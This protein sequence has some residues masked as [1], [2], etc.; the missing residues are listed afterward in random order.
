MIIGKTKVN[1]ILETL[2]LYQM[3]MMNEKLLWEVKWVDTVM[4]LSTDRR[5]M[6]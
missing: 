6:K 3:F 1:V 4:N 5:F 2:Q